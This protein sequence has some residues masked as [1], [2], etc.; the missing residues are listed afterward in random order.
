M[1]KYARVM[2]D[3]SGGNAF[4]YALPEEVGAQ[5]QVG[6]R[7]R[8]PVRTRTVLGTIIELSDTT[9]FEGVK[10]ISQVVST[11]PILSPLLIR[12]GTWIAD[13]YCCPIEAAMRSILPQV[14]RN[15]AVGH[16]TQLFARLAAP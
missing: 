6:C 11:E 4:D 1:P 2:V 12:L 8:V 3:E 9:N 15:A 16:K 5:L 7:V 10:L 14:I 13:Y